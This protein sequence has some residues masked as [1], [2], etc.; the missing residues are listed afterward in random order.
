MKSVFRKIWVHNFRNILTSKFISNNVEEYTE[1]WGSWGLLWV[2]PYVVGSGVN[3]MGSGRKIIN[4][5]SPTAVL[6]QAC[7]FSVLRYFEFL[8]I[9]LHWFYISEI[10]NLAFIIAIIPFISFQRESPFT[11][12]S[13]TQ[14]AVSY[15]H[16]KTEFL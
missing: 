3:W 2:L 4:F 10:E 5:T 12:F 16:C 8:Y 15:L 6:C 1:V 13:M 7:C 9:Y 14:W 11:L